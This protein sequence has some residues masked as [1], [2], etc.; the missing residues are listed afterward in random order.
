MFR[1]AWGVAKNDEKALTALLHRWGSGDAGAFDELMDVAYARLHRMAQAQARQERGGHTLQATAILHE[2]LLRVMD[3]SG[4]SWV[5]RGHFF[6]VTAEMMRR[7]LVDYAR[8]RRRLKRGGDSPHVT[9]LEAASLAAGERAPDLL[10]LDDALSRLKERDVQKAKI[11]ELRFFAGLGGH[12]IAHCL[13]VSP[14]TVQREWQRARTWLYA[15]LQ[16]EQILG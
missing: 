15:D 16:G 8:H 11:V 3:L 7:I 10:E 12:E 9:L 13:Q 2:A 4:L 6:A 5:D 14:A 1:Y